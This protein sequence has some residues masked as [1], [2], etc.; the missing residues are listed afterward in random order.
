MLSTE[1]FS[2]KVPGAKKLMPKWIGPFSVVATVNDA[3]MKLELPAGYKMHNVFHVPQLKPAKGS[4]VA[5]FPP[6]ALMMEGEAFWEVDTIVGHR[7]RKV[8]RR[9]VREFLVRW[10]GYGPEHDT[11]EPERS[12]KDSEP[13]ER[14]IER[15]LAEH[16]G[17]AKTRAS[18][19]R[20]GATL[21]AMCCAV[22]TNATFP[23]SMVSC[24]GCGRGYK[25]RKRARHAWRSAEDGLQAGRGEM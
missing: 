13:V 22:C 2:F 14:E 17:R 6:P 20:A 15:Y 25:G 4:A 19:K 16:G 9:T 24:N 23:D 11:W 5:H 18:R 8:G 21:G 1:N 7:E 3:A 10:A 12:H